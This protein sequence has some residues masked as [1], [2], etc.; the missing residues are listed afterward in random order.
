M[1][2]TD[3]I[4]VKVAGFVVSEVDNPLGARGQGHILT[5]SRIAA[6]QL[7]FDFGSNPA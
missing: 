6:R 7:L 4:V 1:F 5:R 2:G 3:V